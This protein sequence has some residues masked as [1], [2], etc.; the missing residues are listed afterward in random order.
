MCGDITGELAGFCVSVATQRMPGDVIVKAKL[1]LADF[2]SAALVSSEE[3][4]S[5]VKALGVSGGDE[6]A[7]Q[8]LGAATRATAPTAAY[9]TSVSA[10]ATARTDTHVESSSH[11]GMVL[12]P[13]LLAL[14][15]QEDVPAGRLLSAVVVGYEVMCRLGSA[16][17]TPGV[18][19]TFRPTGLTGP[20]AA[21]A[22]CAHLLALDRHGTQ[23]ALGM[24]ASAACGLNEWA[25][26]GT[27][28]HVLHSAMAARAGVEAALLARHKLTAARGAL[29]GEAGLLAGFGARH[30]SSRLIEGLGSGYAIRDIVHKPAPACIY[31]QGPCQLAEEIVRRH[32]PDWKRIEAVGIRLPEQA[33]RYP[34]CNNSG[35]VTDV[36]AA[37]LSVQFSVASVLVTGGIF[38]QN[39]KNL[40]DLGTKQLAAR[41]RLTVDPHLTKEF[42]QRNGSHVE[43]LLDNGSTLVA[44]QDAFP[45]M[46]AVQIVRRFHLAVDPVYGRAGSQAILDCIA[47]LDRIPLSRLLETL[48][49]G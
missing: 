12:F 18:A 9:L 29:E 5:A 30:R 41:S 47:G 23:G 13:A 32:H 48:Q 28:E 7:A 22:A 14:A 40:D 44:E 3:A 1:C 36:V 15:E 45:S 11:P 17:I 27:Q 20:V 33:V 24:A 2:L 26:A 43:V 16:L 6:G 8:V 25:R 19:A 37:Q 34:G 31:V 38:D 42:P 4:R 21:A 10:A 49:S 39:W 46:T 35:P